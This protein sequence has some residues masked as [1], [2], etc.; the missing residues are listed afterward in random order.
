LRYLLDTN[1]CIALLKGRD[2]ALAERARRQDPADLF[3]SSV[4]KG[5]LLFGARHS[6]RVDAN[7]AL[8]DEFFSQFE[9]VPFDDGAAQYYGVTRAV[10][11]KAGTPIG[12]ND[13]LIASTA[14]HHD[15]TLATRNRREFARVPGLRWEE[16]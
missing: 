11:S 7:L 10:L 16:W 4:V 8:L 14:L 2:T 12:A 5:E 3:L 15:L 13:L 6:S 1:V 9:S